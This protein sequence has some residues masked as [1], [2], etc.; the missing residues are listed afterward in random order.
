MIF[1]AVIAGSAFFAQQI[2]DKNKKTL[3]AILLLLL[4]GQVG[5]QLKQRIEMTQNP[6]WSE[7]VALMARVNAVFTG[8]GLD[9]ILSND[10]DEGNT[11]SFAS[12]RKLA[13]LNPGRVHPLFVAEKYRL[14]ETG[15]KK[16]IGLLIS[17]RYQAASATLT[18][19]DFNMRKWEIQFLA[20]VGDFYLYRA[21][22][23][24]L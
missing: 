17:T 19:L 3:T 1:P 24:K 15:G 22:L 5:F 7:S 11:Y 4:L 20:Q 16:E 9:T 2:L 10:Y 23:A 18:Q 6:K 21:K 14:A 12:D 8:A 13:Y